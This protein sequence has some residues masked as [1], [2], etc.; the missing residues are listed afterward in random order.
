[1]IELLAAI[2][3]FTRSTS[4]VGFIAKNNINSLVTLAIQPPNDK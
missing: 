1:M 3:N 4:K 2:R